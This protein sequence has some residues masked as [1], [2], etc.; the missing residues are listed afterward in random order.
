VRERVFGGYAQSS[1]AIRQR[2][3]V[4]P[5]LEEKTGALDV[6]TQKDKRWRMQSDSQFH[7]SGSLVEISV[8]EMNPGEVRVGVV[9]LRL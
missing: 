2:L 9:L 3:S 6:I 5:G 4:L 7:L 8:G 1:V